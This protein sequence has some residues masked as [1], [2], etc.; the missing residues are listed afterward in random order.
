[1]RAALLAVAALIA[2]G[3]GAAGPSQDSGSRVI[4]ASASFQRLGDWRI[5]R[6]ST[7]SGAIDAFGEPST[8]R[9]HEPIHA[10]ARWA[11]LGVTVD[12]GT[13]GG[14]P[15]G[16]TGCTA[17]ELIHVN[18]VRVTS[19]AWRTSLGLRVGSTERSLRRLY[20]RAERNPRGA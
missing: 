11:A 2:A 15:P 5:D 9:V 14:L 8:C 7:L 1:M 20:P 13:L 16:Q 12:L 19:R 17:P 3:S 10:T 6:A 4:R 18:Y